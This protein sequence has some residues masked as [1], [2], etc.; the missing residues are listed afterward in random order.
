MLP[1]MEST[2]HNLAT[3]ETRVYSLPPDRAVVAAHAQ[4]HGDW[5]TWNYAR[6]GSKIEYAQQHVVCG[7]WA[8]RLHFSQ[9]KRIK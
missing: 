3:G 1:S 6:Y 2:A 4:E 7:D 9:A 5:N 8:A